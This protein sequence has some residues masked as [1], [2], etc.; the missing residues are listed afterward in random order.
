MTILQL[1]PELSC[2]ACALPYSNIMMGIMRRLGIWRLL[3]GAPTRPGP[4]GNL[5][6]QKRT[7]NGIWTEMCVSI[8]GRWMCLARAIGQNGE[9]LDFFVRVERGT[10]GVA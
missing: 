6:T 4:A 7:H 3:D 1:H 10:L 9:M 2:W 8:G 5:A